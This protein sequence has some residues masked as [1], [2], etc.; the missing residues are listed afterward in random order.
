MT[1]V[2]AELDTRLAEAGITL[3]QFAQRI[4]IPEQAIHANIGKGWCMIDPL[5]A[6]AFARYWGT[7][8]DFWLGISHQQNVERAREI[9]PRMTFPDHTTLLSGPPC[10]FVDIKIG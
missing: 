1:A 6:A 3:S 10:D 4:G 9:L 5:M 2:L 7:T 8:P